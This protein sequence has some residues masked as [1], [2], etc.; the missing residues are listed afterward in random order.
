VRHCVKEGG[1][2]KQKTKT[3]KQNQKEFGSRQILN[4]LSRKEK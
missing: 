3:Q 1:N 4:Q 2:K